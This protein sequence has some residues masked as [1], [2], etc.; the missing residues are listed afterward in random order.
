MPQKPDKTAANQGPFYSTASAMFPSSSSSALFLIGRALEASLIKL[1][2]PMTLQQICAA[3][4]LEQDFVADIL[5][6]EHY[7][8]TGAYGF[9]RFANMEE[10]SAWADKGR[11]FAGPVD[12]G[13]NPD[14]ADETA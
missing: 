14:K 9:R 10:F 3:T 2:L 6:Q 4:G 13:A 1:H 8:R 7:F 12:A 11:L 5:R